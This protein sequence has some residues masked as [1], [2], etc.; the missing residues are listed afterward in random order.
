M[1]DEPVSREKLTEPL[2]VR[3]TPSTLLRVTEL[4]AKRKNLSP[5]GLLREGLD[6]TLDRYEAQTPAIDPET[7]LLV[8]QAKALGLDL[9]ALI[10][11]ELQTAA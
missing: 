7:A 10:K 6:E 11:R 3:V 8:A 2:M 1:Q 5:A 9:A 4:C